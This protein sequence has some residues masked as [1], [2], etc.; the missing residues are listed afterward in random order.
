MRLA[1]I[2]FSAALCA[3][4]A[5]G[6]ASNP[7]AKLP[8][9]HNEAVRVRVQ[10]G[11]HYLRR[12]EYAQALRVLTEADRRY[13]HLPGP[14]SALALVYERINDAPAAEAHFRRAI[15]RDPH[16]AGIR[17]NYANFLCRRGRYEQALAQFDRAFEDRLYRQP[18]Q[19]HTN[20]GLCARRIPDL[21][22]A[23][24]HLREALRLAPEYPVAL[25]TLAEISLERRRYR[26][27]LDYLARFAAKSPLTAA[28]LQLGVRLARG[29]K[30]RDQELHYTHALRRDFPHSPE[31]HWLL[32]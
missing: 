10:L 11:L 23:Q 28:G 25:Y 29:D 15:E 9:E 14:A 20:A 17:N 26:A 22:L 31:A 8:K 12:E 27:G 4:C 30:D 1:A 5:T 13:P 18:E 6:P 32:H 19:I 21:D 3:A 24:R 16:D 2:L 7:D